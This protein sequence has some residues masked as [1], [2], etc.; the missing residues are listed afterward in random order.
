MQVGQCQSVIMEL[1]V[2]VEAGK[3]AGQKV[4]ELS[5][6][7]AALEPE[8]A[9]SKALVKA[10]KVDQEQSTITLIGLQNQVEE[11]KLQVWDGEQLKANL[12]DVQQQANNLNQLW[13]T[14]MAKSEFESKVDALT[15]QVN[16]ANS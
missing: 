11:L 3:A 13:G 12:L 14:K 7:L 2:Q 15:D 9:A 5:G 6:I 8:L 1:K 10:S 16:D 4:E